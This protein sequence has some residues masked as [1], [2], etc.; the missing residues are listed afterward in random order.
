MTLLMVYTIVSAVVFFLLVI[1]TLVSV[2][3]IAKSKLLPSGD[4]SLVVNG[5][6]TISVS[7]CET[8]LGTLGN[9]K[10]FLVFYITISNDWYR[11]I[12]L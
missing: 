5:E 2:L 11:Y 6:K 4:I 12:F 10:I 7:A 1:L 9:N 3:L 8:I